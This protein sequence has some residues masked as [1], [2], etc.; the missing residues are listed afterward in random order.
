MQW[1]GF[2]LVIVPFGKKDLKVT[3]LVVRYGF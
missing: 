3:I 2:S 1:H